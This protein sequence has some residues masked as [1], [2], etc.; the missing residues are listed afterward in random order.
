MKK[1]ILIF[2]DDVAVLEVLQMVLDYEG[3]EADIVEKSDDFLSLVRLY[4]PSL[5]LMDFSLG[6][7]NGGDWCN[8][9]KKK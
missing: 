5:I 1:R 7:M 9:L 4:K 2:D 6:G 3:F 8:L